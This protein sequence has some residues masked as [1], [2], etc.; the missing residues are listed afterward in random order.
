MGVRGGGATEHL[1]RIPHYHFQWQGRPW[2]KYSKALCK[3]TATMMHAGKLIRSSE[4]YSYPVE[5]LCILGVNVK[6]LPALVRKELT[7]CDLVL[8]HQ[9]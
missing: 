7:N 6:L 3:L 4:R 2:C 1:I 9:L 8:S 5:T